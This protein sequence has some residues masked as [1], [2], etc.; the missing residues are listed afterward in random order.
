MVS[1]QI[2][3]LDEES[4]KNLTQ[5]FDF[6]QLQNSE[7]FLPHANQL[8]E[9]RYEIDVLRLKFPPK[10]QYHKNSSGSANGNSNKPR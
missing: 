2:G 5:I 7:P 3:P 9:L 4:V 1:K 10:S 6:A 8:R